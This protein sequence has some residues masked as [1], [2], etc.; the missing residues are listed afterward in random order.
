MVR[1]TCLI[2]WKKRTSSCLSRLARSTPAMCRMSAQWRICKGFDAPEPLAH[3]KK[4]IALITWS[5]LPEGAE[6]ERLLLP[7]LAGAGAEPHIVDW[8]ATDAD[9]RQFDLVVLP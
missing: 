6:S 7:H 2:R 4:R 1:S 5:G 3:M 8:S 9:F